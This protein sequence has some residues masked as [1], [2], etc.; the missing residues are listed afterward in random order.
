MGDDLDWLPCRDALALTEKTYPSEPVQGDYPAH[1]VALIY[2]AGQGMISCR[3]E[4]L[5]IG[6]PED[7]GGPFGWSDVEFSSRTH[8]GDLLR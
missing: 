7:L 8:G 3:A 6:R 1:L 4:F 5:E 2:Y